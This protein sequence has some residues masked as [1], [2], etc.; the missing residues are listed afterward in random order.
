MCSSKGESGNFSKIYSTKLYDIENKTRK[1]N[2]Q[3]TTK[4]A[5]EYNAVFQYSM[6]KY[7]QNNC[8]EKS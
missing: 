4:S 7:R 3:K 5:T 8:C 6:S 2:K 1:A